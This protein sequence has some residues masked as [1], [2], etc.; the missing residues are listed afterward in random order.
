MAKQSCDIIVIGAGIAGASAAAALAADA[1]VVLLEME[2]Q[3]GYH[4]SGRSAAY[5]AAAYGKPVVQAITRASESFFR[6]PPGGFSEVDLF[7]PREC[8]WFGRP[9][10]APALAAMHEAV[11]RLEFLDEAAVRARVPV[12][13]RGYLHG[14]LLDREGGDLDVEA[15][16]QGCLR[17]FRRNG[18]ALRLDHR[19]TALE[20]NA[21]GWAVT[22]GDA[23]FTAPVVV[24]AA[25]AWAEQVGEWAGLAPLGI[26]PLR[27]TAL[28]IDAPAGMD[29]DDWPEMVDIDETFYFKPDAGAILISPADET[30]TPPVDAQP[31]DLDVAIGV[32]RFERATGIDVRR[33]RAA[34]A[35]LRTFASD[36]VFVAGFDPRA[37]GFFWLAGQGGYG[38][39]ISPAMAALT[40][41]LVT[42]AALGGDFAGLE[43]HVAEIAP[44]RLL[45]AT[46]G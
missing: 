29:I 30:P 23:C 40:R 37:L 24:N 34:W 46:P 36:R 35:G 18:G 12:I 41:H 21:E 15:L 44:Q 19:V 17:L 14:G 1:R 13:R 8:I 28:T 20:P 25:G 32:D 11:P 16:L 33:V 9:D 27:R 3:P 5:F 4:A 26:R 38:V 7:R 45:P 22:A 2:P 39:Q 6:A 10:Q 42:G 31:E 43:R